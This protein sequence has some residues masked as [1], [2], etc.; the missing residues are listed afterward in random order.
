MKLRVLGCGTSSGVPRIGNDWGRCDPAEPKNRRTRSALLIESG[1]ER[2]LVDCGPD[3]R[4]QLLVAEVTTLD[5][6]IVTHDH[7]DHCHGIDDLRQVAQIAGRVVPLRAREDV[8]ERLT[9]RF[10]YT[11]EGT[12]LYPPVLSAEPL[13]EEAAVGTAQ[14]RFVDQPHGGVT[15]LGIRIDENTRS[16][17]YAIDF[18]QL[19]D[20][21]AALYQGVEL[22][23][24]DCLRRRPH[25]T[26]AHLDVVIGWARELGVGQLLLSH[27]DNSMDVAELV[28]ELP[29]W[30]APAFDGQ[31]I[32]FS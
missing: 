32:D 10:R 26:H 11:F 31:E 22:W 23:I 7:A 30:A 8:L 18:K 4:E 12:A 13:D 27:L 24:A 14:L 28:R 20:E 5:A 15:S 9:K 2:L 1:A 21:M 29:D 19:T 6:V 16:A 3:L 25:P 17:A